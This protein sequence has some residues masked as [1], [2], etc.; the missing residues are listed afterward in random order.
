MVVVTTA[1]CADHVAAAAPA[2]RVSV[3]AQPSLPARLVNRLSQSFRR[4]LPSAVP[5]QARRPEV[6]NPA[7]PDHLTDQSMSVQSPPLSP[8]QFR[9]P[10][11]VL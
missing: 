2:A 11:P 6:A 9:L 8:F 10:P 7:A 3:R 5:A 4:V 1:L